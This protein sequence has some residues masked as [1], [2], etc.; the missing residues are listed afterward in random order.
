MIN[1]KHTEINVRELFEEHHSAYF[2][3]IPF[4]HLDGRY[5]VNQAMMG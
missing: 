3:T 2:K 1:Y 4:G 5:I